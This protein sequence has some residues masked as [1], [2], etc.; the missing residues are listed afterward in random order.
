M[1]DEKEKVDEKVNEPSGPDPT[2]NPKVAGFPKFKPAKVKEN[3]K[4]EI[5]APKIPKV[6]KGPIVPRTF[7]VRESAI[8]IH[9][10]TKGGIALGDPVMPNQE[11][12]DLDGSE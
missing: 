2:L 7:K 10:P 5:K 11:D 3:V 12:S 8:A 1:F 6:T 9:R 4:P